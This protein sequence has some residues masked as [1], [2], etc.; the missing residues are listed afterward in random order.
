MG[1]LFCPNCSSEIVCQISPNEFLC[2]NC[3]LIFN[4]AP[5]VI[6]AWLYP[7]KYGL[8]GRAQLASG[9][10]VGLICKYYQPNKLNVFLSTDGLNRIG[11]LHFLPYKQKVLAE[12]LYDQVGFM[13]L[14]GIDYNYLVLEARDRKG[15]LY[16][17][18]L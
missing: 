15:N 12:K 3:G 2:Q 6:E 10:V 5:S 14:F 18:V 8:R 4:P 17:R 13:R 11:I 7:A 1:E 16:Y 9:E